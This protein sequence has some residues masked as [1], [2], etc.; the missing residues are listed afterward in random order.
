[1]NEGSN[2]ILTEG[3]TEFSAHVASDT[4]E[5]EDLNYTI[6][7]TEDNWYKRGVKE[8]IA[9]KKLNPSLNLDGGRHRLSTMYDK[10]IRSSLK[11][12]FP[13]L[14]TQDTTN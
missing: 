1:M 9:I 7:Y 11:L 6:L 12:N 13:D 4:H 8:A 2:Q 3:N 5:K 10:L 14:E